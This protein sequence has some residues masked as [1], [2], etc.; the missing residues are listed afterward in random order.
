M[1][2]G[3]TQ[4]NLS[5]RPG[6]RGIET[7]RKCHGPTSADKPGVRADCVDCHRYHNGDQPLHGRGAAAFDPPK[8][9]TIAE[10]IK[11]GR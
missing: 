4:L 1:K 7:C 8:K 10:W 5:D 2:D 11:T 3:V 6:I 9:L